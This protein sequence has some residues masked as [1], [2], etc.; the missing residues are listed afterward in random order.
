MLLSDPP[1][2]GS[3][4]ITS[5]PSPPSGWAG[6]FTLKLLNMLSTQ[7]SRWRGG[8][9]VLEEGAD[10]ISSLTEKGD[11]CDQTHSADA[12]RTHAPQLCR[13]DHAYL[14]ASGRRFQ[15]LFADAVGPTPAG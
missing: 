3:P 5:S 2:G 13:I 10:Q 4:C 1:R 11:V 12:R 14:F 8:R 6:T 7:R 15:A 9:S